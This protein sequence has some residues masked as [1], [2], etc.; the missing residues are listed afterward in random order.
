[1]DILIFDMD[2]VLIK[3]RGYHRALKETVRQAGISTEFGEVVLSDT[4]IA[5][6]EAVGISSEWHSSA[7][8]MAVMVLEKH[9]GVSRGKGQDQPI[10][11]D[12]EN[13]FA[14]IAAQPM[15][16]PAL[17]RGMAAISELAFQA[18]VPAGQA[19]LLV[20]KSES[21]ELSP[22]M[23]WFQELILGSKKYTS[24]YQKKP[25]FG[26][27]SYL[28]LYDKQLLNTPMA[29]SVLR[30]MENPDHGAVIM[31]RR[32]S[33]DPQEIAGA[34]D[35]DMGAELVGLEGLP[36]VGY[37]ELCWMAEKTGRKVGELS[38]PAHEHALA[39][40]L[41]ASGWSLEKS[42]TYFI[43]PSAEWEMSDL[44]NLNNSTIFVFEDTPVGMIAVQKAGDLLNLLGLQIE[45][46][47]IGIADE[48][49]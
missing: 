49:S 26:T 45:E 16:D 10:I 44:R 27:E 2:G 24:T 48:V 47:K 9:K 35:A 21:I 46:K 12:L 42:L 3:P 4:Q 30:W 29:E 5:Q 8:C 28:I 38:K 13:L 32:P 31:T 17:S 36:I 6:F 20:E 11:L 33:S 37:R 18:N 39:A 1:M 40:I 25:Q 14:A 22:T 43:K 23:K 15:Q 7:L 34:P 41:V 19:C